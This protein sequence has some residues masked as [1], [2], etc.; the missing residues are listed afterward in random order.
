M[1]LVQLVVL[2]ITFS[3]SFTAGLRSELA[4]PE[5]VAHEKVMTM[6]R[7]CPKPTSAARAHA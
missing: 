2:L 1:A 6:T 7:D 3:C 5:D 4:A